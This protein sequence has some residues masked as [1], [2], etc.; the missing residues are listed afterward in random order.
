MPHQPQRL[1]WALALTGAFLYACQSA[2][3][4][5]DSL[6]ARYGLT[7]LLTAGA[8][9]WAGRGIPSQRRAPFPDPTIL[10]LAALA[11][12]SLWAALWWLMDATDHVLQDVVGPLGWPRAIV[13][14]DDRLLG[15][16]LTPI[17][18]EL[19]VLFSVVLIP[20]AQGWLLWGWV[21][22]LLTVYL[23]PRR[24]LLAVGGLGGALLTLSATQNVAPA[25][26]AGLAALP[27]YTLLALFAALTTYLSGSPW[28]GVVVHSSFA[29]AS[30]AWQ[31]DLF[32]AFVGKG[33]FSPS[34]L[35]VIVLGTLGATICLQLMRFRGERPL[36]PPS[37][38]RPLRRADG[39]PALVLIIAVTALIARDVSARHDEAQRRSLPPT[40]QTAQQ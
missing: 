21:Q 25:L 40:S 31:D 2:L 33:Y 19:S 30:L 32:R 15:L 14:L 34:W 39:W 26:P 37:A 24:A 35:T 22:P 13:A 29:Y 28:T 27:G 5:S 17:S 4:R 20:L 8:T 11:A 16:N 7:V 1:L 6:T 12:L 10:T 3:A 23:G 36:P 38:G 18:Y 9:W